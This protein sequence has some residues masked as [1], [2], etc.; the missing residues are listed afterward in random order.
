MMLPLFCLSLAKTAACCNGKK[1]GGE[2]SVLNNRWS[3]TRDIWGY[4]KK[5]ETNLA[6]E[7]GILRFYREETNLATEA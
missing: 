1:R 4:Q 3:M 2:E 5:E 7:C 6:T